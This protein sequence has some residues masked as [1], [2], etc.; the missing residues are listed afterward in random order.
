MSDLLNLLDANLDDL[1]DLKKFEPF[2]A[3]SYRQ[4]ISWEIPDDDEVVIVVFKLK[5]LECLDVPGV[6]EEAYPEAG[7]EA[8]F[9]MRLQLKTGEP[10]TWDDGTP[11]TQDQ[12]RF[13]EILMAL[14]PVFNPDGSLTNRELMEASEGAEVL[15]TLKVKASKKDKDVKFNEIKTLVLAE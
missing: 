9:W 11:N 12:G 13:K 5:N 1:A 8:T 2:P 6:A 7:K 10:L 3:G 14:A 4:Q 15:T